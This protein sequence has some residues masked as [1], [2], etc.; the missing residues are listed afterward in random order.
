MSE[1]LLES[2]LKSVPLLFR[3]KVRDIYDLGDALLLVAS[4]RIS[5]FDHILPTPIPRKGVILTQLSNF[6]LK[7]TEAL[8]PNH[9]LPRALSTVTKDP[10]ELRQLEGR[11]V[12]VK[13]AKPLR[14]ELI[15]RGYLVGS[16]W[17]EYKKQGTVCGIPLPAGIQQAQK[18]PEPIFTPSTKAPKGQHDENI[19]YEEMVKL[20]GPDLAAQ[21]RD[22]C[23]KIYSTAAEYALS[24]GIII[25]DTK[26]E[27]GIHEGKLILIDELLTPDS[28]RF[29]PA[30]Q[31]KTGSNPPSY[32]KQ[33]V[34][35]Y[36]T[37]IHWD[38]KSNPPTL[39]EDI[40]RKTAEKY[41]EALD[42]LTRP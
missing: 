18:L 3:G 19:S 40:V 1:A 20:I 12:V 8:I 41:Q 33:F 25:A 26:I 29:W 30:D 13:K 14:V 32:D 27:L 4:D 9:S 21:A 24:R 31:Y 7:K 10:D 22:I 2:H 6:W 28:S 23:L 15:V 11:S 35:D 37:S 5:A 34:R 36:L 16:G 38:K 39:P 42:R 17:E